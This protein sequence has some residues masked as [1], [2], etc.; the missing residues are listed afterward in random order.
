MAI[1]LTKRL[2]MVQNLDFV[3]IMHGHPL[4][5]RLDGNSD[6]YTGVVVLIAHLED[7]PKGTVAQFAARPIEQSH[8]A[9]GLNQPV[10]D[11]HVSRADM[12]PASQ[13]FAVEKLFPFISL[14]VGSRGNE[15]GKQQESE[16]DHRRP[17]KPSSYTKAEQVTGD[18]PKFQRFA[19]KRI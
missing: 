5:A 12:F 15:Q 16:T 9:M 17:Q 3:P 8:S 4:F 7:N 19:S 2:G 10:F 13:V 11:R 1:V 6:K 18:A 14:R